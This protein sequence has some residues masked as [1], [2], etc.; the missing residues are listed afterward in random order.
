MTTIKN[1]SNALKEIIE[2]LDLRNDLSVKDNNLFYTNAESFPKAKEKIMNHP[3]FL[4]KNKKGASW[5]G[6]YSCTLNSY[7]RFLKDFSIKS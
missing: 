5:G 1:Y 3:D 4:K 7:E 6:L 2:L